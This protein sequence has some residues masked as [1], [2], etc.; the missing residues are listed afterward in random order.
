MVSSGRRVAECVF[1]DHQPLGRAD[2]AAHA[3]VVAVEHLQHRRADD[4]RLRCDRIPAERDRRQDDVFRSAVAECR[5]PVELDRKQQDQQQSDPERRH[6]LAEHGEDPANPIDPGATMYRRHHPHRNRE[7][8]A[9][10]QSGRRQLDGGRQPLED[11]LQRW[12]LPAVRL[13]EIA[14]QRV[15]KEDQVLHPDRLIEAIA[16][17][18]LLDHAERSVVRQQ[19]RES[20]RRTAA[21]SRRSRG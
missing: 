12:H 7:R 20:D 14:L 16:A 11:Q 4:A 6:R 19:Q 1:P 13:A 2:R 18:R 9:E 5:Q 17:P 21:R 3:D 15:A 8:H 10:Q